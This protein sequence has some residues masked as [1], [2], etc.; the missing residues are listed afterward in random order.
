MVGSTFVVPGGSTKHTVLTVNLTTSF[1]P[2]ITGADGYIT[3]DPTNDSEFSSVGLGATFTF[4]SGSLLG[5]VGW[6]AKA[7]TTSKGAIGDRQGMVYAN[8]NTIYVCYTSYTD[9]V[10]DIWAK[11]TTDST[12]W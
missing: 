10:K 8:S 3:V 7:P 9:G 12:T 6:S 2:T 1:P 4:K 11:T 5:A